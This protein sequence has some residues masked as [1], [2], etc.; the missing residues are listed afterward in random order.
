MY[1]L[2]KRHFTGRFHCTSINPR[3][4]HVKIKS[5]ATI[6]SPPQMFNLSADQYAPYPGTLMH[7]AM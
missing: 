2:P 1:L 4:N 5:R 7:A 3:A 6:E